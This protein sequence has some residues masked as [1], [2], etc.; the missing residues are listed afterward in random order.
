MN[1][2]D[3][4]CILGYFKKPCLANS[5]SFNDFLISKM[6]ACLDYLNFILIKFELYI[7][8]VS[9]FNAFLAFIFQ[10]NPC[11]AY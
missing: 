3:Y 10:I 8:V 9:Y 7:N 6:F 5:A 11:K 1:N 4:F 2:I